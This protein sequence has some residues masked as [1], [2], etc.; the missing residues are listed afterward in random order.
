MNGTRLREVLTPA[1]PAE[2]SAVAAADPRTLVSQTP[3]ARAWGAADG[4]RLYVFLDGTRAV[5]PGVR[6]GDAELRRRHGHARRHGPAAGDERL[7]VRALV[8]RR[9]RRGQVLRP[10]VGHPVR[11]RHEQAPRVAVVPGRAVPAVVARLLL[12]FRR[13]A[14]REREHVVVLDAL[15]VVARLLRRLLRVAL[16]A[17]PPALLLLGRHGRRLWSC[18]SG[19]ALL[20]LLRDASTRP[21]ESML[22]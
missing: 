10:R 14:G 7:D 13:G 5:L 19:A 1:P 22:D 9:R 17:E 21:V 20:S 6:E 11:L 8:E 18:S 12:L 2:W 4:S 15:P 16:R 3:A